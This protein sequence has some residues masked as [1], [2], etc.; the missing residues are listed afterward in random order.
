M[1]IPPAQKL[2]KLSVV[3]RLAGGLSSSPPLVVSLRFNS[4]LPRRLP[5]PS[6]MLPDGLG[7]AGVS[8]DERG[9]VDAPAAA[10]PSVGTGT[11]EL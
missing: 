10:L 7:D 2:M 4:L 9:G 5:V 3:R 6:S 11:F 8:T 1:T